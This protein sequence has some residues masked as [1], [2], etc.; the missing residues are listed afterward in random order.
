MR[1]TYSLVAAIGVFS[2]IGGL[3]FT[4]SSEGA[5]TPVVVSA[6]VASAV[7][8]S[9]NTATTAF[10]TLTSGAVSTATTDA[11][12]TIS[13]NYPLGCT[14]SIQDANSGLATTSPAYTITSATALL[15]AGTEGYGIQATS[16]VIGS[17]ATLT[18]N[19]LFGGSKFGTNN[20]GALTGGAVTLASSTAAIS[21][22]EVVVRHKAA[23]SGT[24]P[25]GSYSDT[26]TYNCVG[27]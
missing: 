18:F 13:C 7:S 5:I 26:I 27:N 21:N 4:S 10:G 9:A 23:I 15:A 22:R 19:T 1:K 24:T 25:G 6:T 3:W 14:L 17:G 12:S 8:C 11:S 16:T 20:V 2:L